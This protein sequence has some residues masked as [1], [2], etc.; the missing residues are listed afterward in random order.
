[1]IAPNSSL[2]LLLSLIFIIAAA[3]TVELAHSFFLTTATSSLPT[4][5]FTVT[6]V[7]I[8]DQ[9]QST[10]TKTSSRGE[11]IKNGES[12]ILIEDLVSAEECTFL[13]REV[14]RQD[15]TPTALE[16]PGLVRIPTRS[17]AERA[18]AFDIPC[19]DPLSA[20]VDNMLHTILKRAT[21]VMTQQIPSIS[22]VLFGGESVCHLL[23]TD[24]LKFSSREPAINIYTPDG[25]FL[26][27]KDAQAITVLIPLS[28]PDHH[29][30]GG[31]TSFWSQD[32]RGHR[33]ED[34]TIILKPA[35][36]SAMLFGGC[37]THAGVSVN[38]GT[39]VVFVASFS[40]ASEETPVVT[41]HRDIYGDSL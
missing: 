15:A 21:N 5:T 22:E 14:L 8:D 1:M 28:C 32:S 23:D 10:A 41:E 9:D 29:F 12:I 18:A 4:R 35:A 24:Q 17:A 31:G 16:K 11:R 38:K 33:V 34:P 36:G 19:A 13:I 39:R 2:P 20:E 6:D 40:R 7:P 27:H 26:A 30:Q 25:Q 3:T 37:V